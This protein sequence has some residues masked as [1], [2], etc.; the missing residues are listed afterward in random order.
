MKGL[1]EGLAKARKAT[2]VKARETP[3]ESYSGAVGMIGST[4]SDMRAEISRLQSEAPTLLDPDRIK[5]SRFRDRLDIEH[6][7]DDLV[8][9]I[10]ESGQRIPILVRRS[11]DD[12]QYEV[13]YG[14]RR[15]AAC[16]RLGIQVKA[17]VSDLSDDEA[18]IAQ[19]VENAARLETSYIE[20]AY[21]ASQIRAAGKSEAEIAS[22]LGVQ[23]PSVSRMKTLLEAIPEDLIEA[24]GPVPDGR[25]RWDA[26]KDA[27]GAFQAPPTVSQL[28]EMV[29]QSVDVDKRLESLLKALESYRRKTE[30]AGTKPAPRAT[31]VR[32]IA[33]NR[34]S[35]SRKGRGISI[36]ISSDTDAAFADFL[37][38]RLDDM[39]T[40]WSGQ[41]GK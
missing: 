24:L 16:R 2:E 30:G 40:E 37:D 13:V 10:S 32:K 28:V 14:R 18:L 12:D 35:V 25:R 36:S 34:V 3:P 21:F 7:L 5:A 33:E 11:G 1:K 20:R 27:L 6:G 4:L 26:V 17:L 9:S 15:I 41:Q 29:D 19:G 22:I 8:Q 31:T 23:R 39:F 38:E